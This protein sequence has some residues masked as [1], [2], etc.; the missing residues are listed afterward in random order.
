MNLRRSP[1][2]LLF[3]MGILIPEYGVIFMNKGPAVLGL[4]RCS[5]HIIN[6]CALLKIP[7]LLSWN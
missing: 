4:R 6:V 3:I 2:R 5:K 1:D 7:I